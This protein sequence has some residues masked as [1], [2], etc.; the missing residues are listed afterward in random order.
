MN[1]YSIYK[2]TNTHNS[3]VYIGFSKNFEYRKYR[4]KHFAFSKKKINC[5][6]TALR[7]YGWE[8]FNWQIIYQSKDKLHCL[9]EMENYFIN[10]YRSFVGFTDCH[11]YN[12]TLGGDG[13]VGH[14]LPKSKE[15]KEKISKALSGKNKSKQHILKASFARSKEYKMI[16]PQGNFIIIK[17]MSEFCRKNNLNQSHMISVCKGRYGFVSHKGYKQYA[18]S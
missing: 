17:N 18:P 15:H 12:M 14:H 6:Y 7:K 1:V 3:K 4:H 13:T 2:V 8:C 16:D 5:F 11:G 9:N 10:E